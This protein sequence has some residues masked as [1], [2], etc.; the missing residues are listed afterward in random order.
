MPV[1]WSLVIFS[2]LAGCAAAL[3]VFIGFAE[4]TNKAKKACFLASV[5][6]AALLVIGGIA[7]VTHLGNPVNVMSALTNVLSF[8]GIS[9]ELIFL[10]LCLI[11]AT[12]YA[13]VCKR[14]S[15]A[16]KA[17]SVAALLLG[18]VFCVILG[19]SYMIAARP[20]WNNIGLPLMYFGSGLAMG[21]FL[22]LALSMAVKDQESD[23]KAVGRWAVI[24][25]VVAFAAYLFFGFASGAAT[26]AGQPA[27]FWAALAIGTVIPVLCAALIQRYSKNGILAY[28]GLTATVVG[29]ACI[30]VLMWAV[31]TGVLDIFGSAKAFVPF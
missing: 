18:L 2:L 25:T 19:S 31:G 24:A 16:A 15:S 22:Y 23:I 10:G 8:S 3:L 21:S 9:L 11:S 7:S 20:A 30:R 6:A 4:L 14:K 17:V 26:S 5:I 13:V 28:A 27:L 29:A 12:A 1:Q